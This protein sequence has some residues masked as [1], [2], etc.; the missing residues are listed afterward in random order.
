MEDLRQAGDR[1]HDKKLRCPKPPGAINCSRCAR[2]NVPCIFSPPTRP[3]RPGSH[4]VPFDWSSFPALDLATPPQPTSDTP[5]AGTATA[6]LAEILVALDR[7]WRLL[8]SQESHQDVQRQLG[9][10]ADDV[11]SAVLKLSVRHVH[12]TESARADEGEAILP[13][14]GHPNGILNERSRL[15]SFDHA[16]LNLLLA[17]HLRLLDVLDSLAVLA[18][19]CANLAS[20]LPDYDPKFDV[21]EIRIGSFIAPKNTAASI[22]I[23][24]VLDLHILLMDKSRKLVAILSSPGANTALTREAEMIGLQFDILRD[25]ADATLQEMEKLKDHLVSAGVLRGVSSLLHPHIQA[26]LFRSPVLPGPEVRPEATW[27]PPDGLVI[28]VEELCRQKSPDLCPSRY[29]TSF[30]KTLTFLLTS[31]H[32]SVVD[33]GEAEESGG[34]AHASYCG[35][36][37]MVQYPE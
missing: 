23:S 22:F 34:L 27:E 19:T 33:D 13:D 32:P 18:Q 31:M 17:C 12:V 6:K 4:S 11:G 25:R 3:L 30:S 35:E 24:M 1:C 14:C 5:L 9:Q 7:I 2:A 37:V 29:E 20:S 36:T 16:M 26:Q 10:C 21:P 15:P 8:S 28:L